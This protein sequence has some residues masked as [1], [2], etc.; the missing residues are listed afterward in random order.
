MYPK[1]IVLP[2]K[3]ELIEHGFEDL[4]SPELLLA[5]LQRKGTSIIVINSV[6]GCAAGTCRPGVIMS[7]LNSEKKPTHL[8]TCFAGFDIDA[9]QLLRQHLLPY[10]PSS[11]AIAFFKDG[12]MTHF[13]ERHLIEAR[14]AQLIAES[15]ID[16]Y[17]KN[18]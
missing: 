3:N 18:C 16:I 5:F 12:Q 15:L 1:E 6:C 7:I 4:S 11:P 10:P 14:P 2:L 9:V 13:I 17:T 8:G